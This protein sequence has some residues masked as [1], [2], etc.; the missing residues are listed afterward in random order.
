MDK[1]ALRL[2][3]APPVWSEESAIIIGM[4]SYTCNIPVAQSGLSNQTVVLID[5]C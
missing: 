5:R 2:A 3:T 4:K 1:D